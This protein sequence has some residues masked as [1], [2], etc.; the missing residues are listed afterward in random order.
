MATYFLSTGQAVPCTV[1]QVD[2][3]QVS[4]QIGFAPVTPPPTHDANGSPVKVPKVAPY[5]ALQVAASDVMSSRGISKTIVG[6]LMKAGI[7]R[8]KK[9]LS[10]FKISADAVLPLGELR[11]QKGSFH[12]VGDAHTQLLFSMQERSFPHLTS[13]QGKQSMYPQSPAARDSKVP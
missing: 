11:L 6:H 5:L 1:L 3:N 2:A 7:N 12:K 13:S 9:V 10:E 4:A 8:P